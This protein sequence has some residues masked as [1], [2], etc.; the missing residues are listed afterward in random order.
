MKRPLTLEDRKMIREGLDAKWSIPY[1]AQI[2]GLQMTSIYA[3]LQKFPTREEYDPIAAHERS[4]SVGN[5]KRTLLSKEQAQKIIELRLQGVSTADIAKGLGVSLT[6]VRGLLGRN[7]INPIPS[8]QIPLE[9]RIAS[10]EMQ[11]EII[12]ETLNKLTKGK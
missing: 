9:E 8:K 3:E 5:R 2:I 6:C 7:K 11:I 4:Y 12:I 10:I 1:M